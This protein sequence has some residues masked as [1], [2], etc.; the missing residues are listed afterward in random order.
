MITRTVD[1]LVIGAGIAGARAAIELSTYGDVVVLTKSSPSESS[2]EYAQGG[3][4][5]ALSD[6]DRVGLHYR[7]TLEAGDGLC[8]EE[9][10]SVLV[11]EGPRH[12]EQLVKWGVR[13][14][15]KGGKLAFTLEGAHSQH[16]VLHA[17]G[18]STGHEVMKTLIATAKKNDR[19]T[20][21]PDAYAHVINCSDRG[22][23][24]VQYLNL[25]RGKLETIRARGTLLA[26]G[27]GGR[28]FRETT[29]PPLATGD[30][31]RLAFEAGAVLQDMEFVQ[32]HPTCLSAPGSP[33]FLLTEALRGEGAKLVNSDGEAF[34][35]KVHPRGELAP[36][37]V[38]SRA[39]LHEMRRTGAS[40]LYLDVTHLSERYLRERFPRVFGG[41]QRHGM[42]MAKEVLPILPSAHYLMGGVMTDVWGRSSLPGMYAAGEVACT[43][44]HGANRL[45]SNS[46]LEGL[47][48][49]ARAGKAMGEEMSG[50]RLPRLALAHNLV[51]GGEGELFHREAVVQSLMWDRVGIERTGTEL[52]EALETLM[53]WDYSLARLRL[54]R[55]N[56]EIASTL[57]LARLITYAALQREESRGAHF[58]TD[59]PRKQAA[60]QKHQEVTETLLRPPSFHRGGDLSLPNN[61]PT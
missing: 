42:N 14:D 26:T 58:R 51:S 30:G 32:F 39:M 29:N 12:I 13:F 47:V 11:E 35:G 18:D 10:V 23:E 2:T 4:A 43:G 34:L 31:Y 48:F 20:L 36:R 17:G 49:G 38:V 59:F 61:V 41:V 19:I 5:V 8:D 53:S 44:V 6:E 54:E 37:D 50:R 16:R 21:Q 27:G 40:H 9:A 55:R 25:R 28:V 57:I 7:D 33:R 52:R 60:W 3:I 22:V 24:G 1:F 15:R 45:A 56:L 46:L